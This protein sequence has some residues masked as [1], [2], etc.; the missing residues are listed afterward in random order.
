MR[1]IF[2][3]DRPRSPLGFTGERLTTAVGGQLQI[4]HYHRYFLAREICRGKEVLDIASGEGYGTAFL[5]Q[6]AHS[7]TGVELMPEVAAHA[8]RAY[9]RSNLRFVAGDVRSIPLRSA[10]IDVVVSFETLEHIYEHD[11]FVAEIR[12]V[13]RPGGVLIMSTPDKAIYSPSGTTENQFHVRELTREE[14]TATLRRRFSHVTCLA[15]RSIIG[16]AILPDPSA[17]LAASPITFERLDQERFEVSEGLPRAPYII[18]V[19]S[20]HPIELPLATLYIE[21]GRLATEEIELVAAQERVRELSREVAIAR[22]LL[23]N[24]THQLW[25]S[26][27]WRL[28][29]PLRNL[30]LRRRGGTIETEPVPASMA[31]AIRTN[32]VVRQSLS[33]ELTSPLRILHRIFSRARAAGRSRVD[34]REA[35]SVAGPVAGVLTS[36]QWQTLRARGAVAPGGMRLPMAPVVPTNRVCDARSEQ[37]RSAAH[38]AVAG[39]AFCTQR[40]L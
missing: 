30:A 28:L 36:T 32:I 16:A 20:D 14:F 10:S 3:Q 13:M 37:D 5:A 18:A 25:N 34:N 17:R 40:K 6:V 8:A 22:Q 2:R 15:Q 39:A 29:Q 21:S 12:R 19:A 26:S 4:E 9:S 27:S 23:A 33:W 35:R 1:E 31:D 38:P 11:T 7:V 24:E